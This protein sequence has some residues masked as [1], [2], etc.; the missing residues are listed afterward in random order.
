MSESPQLGYPDGWFRLVDANDVQPGSVVTAR[1]SGRPWVVFRT[2]AGELSVAEAHCP[3][4]GAHLGHGGRVVGDTLQCPF[5]GLRFGADGACHGTGTSGAPRPKLRL[6]T[7]PARDFHGQVMAFLGSEDDAP[8]WPLPDLDDHGFS[9]AASRTLS[10]QGH[11]QDVAE[12]GVDHGHFA[13]VHGYFNVRDVEYSVQG[14][15]L[16]TKFAFDRHNPLGRRLPPVSAVFDT[17]VHGLGCSI[18]HLHIESWKLQARLLLLATQVAPREFDFTISAQVREPGWTRTAPRVA[19][20]WGAR[21]FLEFFLR[22]VVGDV[23]QDREIWAHRQFLARPRLMAGDGPI[24]TF[25]KYARQFY[26]NGRPCVV[27]P[28]E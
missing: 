17:E 14:R 12:N 23:L 7:L 6:R 2:E 9:R 22:N 26:S 20:R 4:L 5:H 21:A 13:S 18:T 11:V 3:H 28:P 27:S 1:V 19:R 24:G 15:V 16:R 10:L 25:R 8:R